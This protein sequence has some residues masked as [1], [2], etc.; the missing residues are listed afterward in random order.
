MTPHEVLMQAIGEDLLGALNTRPSVNITL[1]D[2]VTRAID[3][4]DAAGYVIAPKEPAPLPVYATSP[5]P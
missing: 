1:G 3:A 4:L 5:K 2:L